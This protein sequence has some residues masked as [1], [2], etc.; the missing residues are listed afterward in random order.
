MR[1]PLYLL[2]AMLLVSAVGPAHACS[3]R[4]LP[5]SDADL[6]AKASAV[7]VARIARADEVEMPHPYGGRGAPAVEATF[8]LIEVLKGR[9]PADGKVRGPLPHLCTRSL[10]VGLDYVI[11]LDADDDNF[12]LWSQDNGTRPLPIDMPNGGSTPNSED[13]WCRSTR[14]QLEMGKLRELAGKSP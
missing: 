8:R 5:L 7:F 10:L 11:F 4:Y 9:P 1:K 3:G 6:F 14:C 12:I 2:L 13:K